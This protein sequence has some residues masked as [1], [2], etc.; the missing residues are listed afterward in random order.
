MEK[1][2][3]YL[4][5]FIVGFVSVFSLIVYVRQFLYAVIIAHRQQWEYMPYSVP[6]ARIF[7]MILFFVLSILIIIQSPSVFKLILPV[8]LIYALINIDVS[9]RDTHLLVTDAYDRFIEYTF[10]P[11]TD[12]DSYEL[13]SPDKMNLFLFCLEP[14]YDD[15]FLRVYPSLSKNW[16]Q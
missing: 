11:Y 7:C 16:E 14:S 3:C 5:A 12:P 1:I 13:P 8:Y 10:N 2:I 6:I 9:L 4:A 15:Y